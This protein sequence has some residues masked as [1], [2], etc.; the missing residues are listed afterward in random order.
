VEVIEVVL[1]PN[2]QDKTMNPISRGIFQKWTRHREKRH[3]KQ[4]QQQQQQQ[5][6]QQQQKKE[7][8]Q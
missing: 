5:Q 3:Q 1:L 4:Q 6:K 2:D 8:Q 7:L